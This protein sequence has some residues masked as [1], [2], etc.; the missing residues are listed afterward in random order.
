M[1]ISLAGGAP[2]LA[3][4]APLL[5]APRAA[6]EESA[7]GTCPFYQ[8]LECSGHGMCVA[9]EGGSVCKCEEGYQREDCSYANFWCVAGFAAAAFAGGFDFGLSA[10]AAVSTLVSPSTAAI[11]E[12]FFDIFC[13]GS[14]NTST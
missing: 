4:L 12:S 13:S 11:T 9:A 5:L 3:A 6:C 10:G 1:R 2:L 8:Q 14:L 7:T